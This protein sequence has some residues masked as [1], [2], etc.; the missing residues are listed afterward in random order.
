M[1]PHAV[2]RVG[3]APVLRIAVIALTVAIA[4]AF[5]VAPLVFIFAKAFSAGAAIYLQKIADPGMLHAI[6]LTV[7]TALVVVPV[8]IVFGLSAGWLVERHRFFGRGAVLTVLELPVSV[9]PIVAG[10]AYL[11]LY[12]AQGWFGPFL[13]DHG[14]RIMFTVPA[15]FLVS[16]FVTCPFIA[17]EVITSLQSR[18]VDDEEAALTLGAGGLTTFLRVT[19]PNIRIGVLYGV[20]LCNARVMGEFGAV[21]VVSG[22]I[23]EKTNTLPLHIELLFNDYNT[24][25]AFAAAS[26]LTLV[27]L[28]T[29]GVRMAIDARSGP[30]SGR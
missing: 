3:D 6:G 7:L 22:K 24:T 18:G 17:R 12:G 8:N 29:L 9:S 21:S 2:R 14:W 28:A 23:R 20:I 11:F 27:A 16:A 26:I 13:E 4:S 15:I 1:R 10:V 5:L 19:L 25:G 30:D